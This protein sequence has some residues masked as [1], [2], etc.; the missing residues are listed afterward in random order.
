MKLK[1]QLLLV[2]LFA[3]S[4]FYAQTFN[5]APILTASG[6]QIY[7]PLTSMKIVTDMTIV[8]PDN[9]GIDAIYIQ[10]SSG[11]TIGTDVLTLTGTHPT[12]SSSWNPTLGK[13]TLSGITSQPTYTALIAAIKDVEFSNSSPN[14]SGIRTFS[15]TV[16]EANY[17]PSNG[18]YYQYISNIG[19]SW[20]SA[21]ALAELSQYY[22]LQGYLATITSAEEKQLSGE[23]AA[24]AGWI[25]GSDQETE[26]VWKWMTGPEAGTNF[27]Y[28]FWNNGEPNNLGAED[29]AHI[30]APGVGILG[31]WNDLSNTGEASGNYQP[32]GYI[33]EYGGTPGDPILQIS[34]SSTITIPSITSTTP[35]SNCDSASM[36]LQATTNIGT[37]N[38]YTNPS[39]G[40]PIH[41]GTS[42]TT[43]VL[44]TTTTYYVDS[45]PSGC[46]SGTRTAITATINQVP[47]VT[48]NPVTP[49]CEGTTA[50]ITASTNF[51]TIS[52]FDSITSTSPIATGPTFVTPNL[53]S[54]TTYYAQANNNGC[55][56]PRVS[57]LVSV[58]QIPV[59]NDETIEI[60]ENDTLIL[61]AG[62]TGLSYLWSTGETTQSVVYNG[63]NNY[64]VVITNSSN[65]SKTKNFTIIEYAEPIIQEVLVE[66][67][68]ATIIMTQAGDYEYSIDGVN[69]QDSNVFTIQQGGLYIAYAKEKHGCGLD[70]QSFVVIS[71]PLFFTPNGDGIN[72]NWIIKGLTHYPNAK[73]GIFDRYG[74]LII[75]L[76]ATKFFWDGTYNGQQLIS[77][78]YWFTL[79]IDDTTPEVKGHFSMIR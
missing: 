4:Y 62:I 29:Y 1:K 69:Y 39:G 68:T 44:T 56:S 50:S 31:S 20:T 26:G 53:S 2:L 35:A 5:V 48:L 25:G 74:K 34:T 72:D 27:S 7:C 19:V 49:I 11:Y 9:T 77:D 65:C 54:N 10:I 38:W 18:H 17:L 30:T 76:T 47:T 24:G 64:S 33:V 59:V 58:N 61:N 57:V 32:K 71:I 55:L 75:Q 60:C 79:K 22:G 3:Q 28:T 67:S 14:P 23:Q 36:T 73:V 51:G 40:T 37:I 12:I 6:N 13:L 45:F 70:T 41:T 52:W 42:F 46:T 15:I 63:S 43:P 21:K 16:G 66:E 78:D 8:D